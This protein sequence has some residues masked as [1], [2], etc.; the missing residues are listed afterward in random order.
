MEVTERILQVPFPVWQVPVQNVVPQVDD[1]QIAEPAAI[2][3]L[4]REGP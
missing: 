2:C 4:G 1:C 3:P